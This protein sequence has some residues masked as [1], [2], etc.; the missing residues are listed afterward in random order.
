M[1][2]NNKNNWASSVCFTLY[3][4][5]YGHVGENQGVCHIRS[6][7]WELKQKLSDCYLQGW[8]SNIKSKDRY[9]FLSSFKQTHILSQYLL[10]VRNLALKRN[11]V[12]LRDFSSFLKPHRPRSSKATRGNFD[13]PFCEDNYES[14]KHTSCWYARNIQ[15]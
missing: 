5:G 2:Y 3:R 8:N 9:S 12:R 15:S 1:H 14:E 13:C 10:P 4:Y 7:L 11:L 6:L